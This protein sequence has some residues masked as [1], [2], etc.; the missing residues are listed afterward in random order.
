MEFLIYMSN[1]KEIHIWDLQTS[2]IYIKFNRDFREK[3]FKLAREKFGNFNLVGKFL[4]VKRPD[5]TIA[6]NW[7]YGTNCCP[8]DLMIKL[9]NQ[10]GIPVQDLEKNIEEIRYKTKISKRGGSR[11]KTGKKP[12]NPSRFK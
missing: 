4:N 10:I 5:T 2:Y 1:F 8:L 12:Q 6:K 7:R 9:A 11:G 3:F